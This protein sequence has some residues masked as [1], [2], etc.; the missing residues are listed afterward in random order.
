MRW[1]VILA[2]PPAV[3]AALVSANE[4]GNLHVTIR[5]PNSRERFPIPET[6]QYPTRIVNVPKRADGGGGGAGAGGAGT[7][8]GGGGGAEAGNRVI[9]NPFIG[10]V[11]LPLPQVAVAAERFCAHHRA[12]RRRSASAATLEVTVIR[13]TEKTRVIVPPR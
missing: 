6:R 2:A 5:N 7:P 12:V 3:A 8:R 10:P 1:R 13:G 4:A 11:T 9:N